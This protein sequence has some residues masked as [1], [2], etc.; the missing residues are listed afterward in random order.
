MTSGVG[1][2]NYDTPEV[3]CIYVHTQTRGRAGTLG[4]RYIRAKTMLGTSK[5]APGLTYTVWELY[6]YVYCV[7]KEE[8]LML[9]TF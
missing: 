1:N 7:F 3:P 6:M 8:L 4:H 9:P 2:K 5:G